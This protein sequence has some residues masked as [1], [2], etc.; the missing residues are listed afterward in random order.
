MEGK[1][2][3]EEGKDDE[4]EDKE[5][6]EEEEDKDGENMLKLYD[7]YDDGF[8][9][10]EWAIDKVLKHKDK[11]MKNVR[12]Y[13]DKGAD[14]KVVKKLVKER[15]P[16]NIATDLP[17]QHYNKEKLKKEFGWEEGYYNTYYKACKEKKLAPNI[18]VYTPAYF[19]PFLDG[20]HPDKITDYVKDGLFLH[21]INCVAYAFDHK[22]QVDYKYFK[23]KK[24]N[25]VKKDLIFRYKMIF[26]KIFKCVEDLDSET[27]VKTIVMPLIG[28]GYFSN[29]IL[30]EADDDDEDSAI[31]FIR[32]IFAPAFFY[33]L[34]NWQRSSEVKFMF[35]GITD[36]KRFKIFEEHIQNRKWNKKQSK[37][38]I[39]WKF[40]DIGFF[41]DIFNDQHWKQED[42]DNILFVNECGPLSLPGNGQMQA[43]TNVNGMIGARTTIALTGSNMTNTYIE[44]YIAVKKVTKP[45]R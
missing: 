32:D 41:P 43:R 1:D 28:D 37:L 38:T 26:S 40:E 24:W 21:I 15:E 14:L 27:K 31:I 29:H 2:D 8:A 34:G 23:N 13:Y 20:A 7:I 5:E 42:L 4:E 22:D 19:S 18:A 39:R 12:V 10:P 33:C 17:P 25:I 36:Q 16:V 30:P 6:E 45:K 9:F 11:L 44:H 35:M 3:E